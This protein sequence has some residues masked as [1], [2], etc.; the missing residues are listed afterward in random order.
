MSV[1]YRLVESDG[2]L[3]RAV[4]ELTSEGDR[5]A[6]LAVDTETSGL[7]P[8]ARDARLLLVQIGDREG[9]VW[10]ID[11]RRVDL[12]LLRPVFTPIGC[13]WPITRSS[14][15]SGC[16]SRAASRCPGSFARCWPS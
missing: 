13:S 3:A 16:W 6:T 15:T 1:P 12:T 4:A 10:V 9:N 14:I 5:Y 8:L 2:Q 11:A 7:D